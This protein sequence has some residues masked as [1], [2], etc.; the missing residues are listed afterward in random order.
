VGTEGEARNLAATMSVH[1]R[2]G[3]SHGRGAVRAAIGGLVAAVV[4]AACSSSIDVRAIGTP[5]P[6]TTQPPSATGATSGSTPSTTAPPPSTS[7]PSTAPA[8]TAPPTT[9]PDPATVFSTNGSRTTRP[10]DGPLSA[11]IVDIQAYWRT[12][13]PQVYNAPYSDLQGGVWPV[14]PGARG[15]PG[16]GE[17]QT[18]FRDIEGNAFYCP[19]GD[20]MA[21]DD[22]ELF[23]NI[24]DQFG[25]SDV[26][27]MIVAHE[28][29]H[30]IQ[31]RAGVQ[32][33][34][35]V[36]EQQA[37]CFAG[38]WMAHL[39]AD[40][41]PIAVNDETLNVA[42]AGMV[43]FS[44]DPGT[45]ANVE[46]AHGSGFDRVS[47]FQD[48]FANG[49]A[50]C[51]TYAASPPPVIELPITRDDAQTGGNL[52]FD[53]IVPSTIDDLDR[54]WAHVFA[55]RGATYAKPAGGVQ[56]YAAAGPYP[57]CSGTTPDAAFYRGRV[58]YCPAGDFIAYDQDTLGGR[59]YDIGDFAVS[60]L[61]GNAWADAMQNRLGVQETGKQRSLDGDCLTGAWTRSTLPVANGG[62]SDQLLT[63]SAGDLD[64]GVVSFLRFGTGEEG[65][66]TDQ[67]GTVFDR[68]SSFRKGI[69]NGVSACG[70]G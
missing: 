35:I 1:G 20:F 55:D 33:T 24:Y 50:Q 49:A 15:V 36:L 54:F 25:S 31:E 34:T 30:A 44:D 7:P 59:V 11:A 63:L 42:I 61:I 38:A 23:P 8:S 28:W 65:D 32:G 60:V 19:E 10:Y 29:G 16:C 51:G 22:Q 40:G 4:L 58:W 69:L 27:A 62:D 37:D 17:P 70:I 53:K 57:P 66:R 46:G 64:E 26:L 48:G 2:S 43:S 5:A 13:F 39:A 45:T 3:G 47:A 12:T 14:Q 67:V 21:F 68:V 18:R 41:G 52:T 56:P 9:P 6:T